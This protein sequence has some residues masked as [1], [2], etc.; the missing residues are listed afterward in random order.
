M[1]IKLCI[2]R[3]KKR[4]DGSYSL[5]FSFADGGKTRYLASGVTI[6]TPKNFKNG[7]ITGEPNASYKNAKLNQQLIDFQ[8][9]YDNLPLHLKHAKLDT[10]VSALRTPKA[11]TLSFREYAQKIIDRYKSQGKGS[12]SVK[13]QALNKFTATHGNLPLE[14]ITKA[15]IMK[16]MEDMQKTI[17]DTSIGMYLREIRAIYNMAVGDEQL[18]L[19]DTHPFKGIKIPKGRKREVALTAEN[20]QAIQK[21]IP[22]YKPEQI[23]KDMLMI[24]LCLGGI[25]MKDLVTLPPAE[26]GRVFY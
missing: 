23:A 2:R 10:I 24:M 15:T 26:N 8:K 17:C 18:A 16:V 25:N 13:E 9:V 22:K 20:I 14:L 1:V 21:I 7:Q 4:T 19:V 5:Y 11:N 3:A 12:W 6:L